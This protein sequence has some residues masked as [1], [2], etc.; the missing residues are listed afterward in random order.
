MKVL[1]AD[2]EKT[3]A[4]TL[5]DALREAGHTVTVVMDGEKALTAVKGEPFDCVICD[6]RMPRV[7]GLALLKAAKEVQPDVEIILITAYGTDEI[8]FRAAKDGAFGWI[9]KPFFN[10]DV[11]TELVKVDKQ[12]KLRQEVS[13]LRRQV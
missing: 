3:I 5:G 10:E 2:D 8:A 9:R 11:V 6:I 1:L 12:L 7:D 13:R 4:V